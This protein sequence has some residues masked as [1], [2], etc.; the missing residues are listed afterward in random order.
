MSNEH[1]HDSVTPDLRN[2]LIY[3]LVQAIFPTSDPAAIHDKRMEN[4]V[5]YARKIENDMY[6]RA[7]ARSEYYY[8]LAAKIYKIQNE[9]EERRQKRKE[10]Q[11]Q[12]QQSSSSQT[13][14]NGLDD[15]SYESLRDLTEIIDN[16]S[17]E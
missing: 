11:Q 1:W 9:L 10:Q 3:K 4:L 13:N 17:L 16:L 7:N 15:G 6:E 2:H 5:K 8:L 14:V 12:M